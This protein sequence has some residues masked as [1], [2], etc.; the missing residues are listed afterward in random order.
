MQNATVANRLGKLMKR[1]SMFFRH[2]ERLGI[3]LCEL[4][5]HCEAGN[6]EL[7]DIKVFKEY[8]RSLPRR[9]SGIP[10]RG[11]WRCL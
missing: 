8:I 5:R 6:I 3:F 7:G 2:G 11:C 9:N 10:R 4:H 1:Q